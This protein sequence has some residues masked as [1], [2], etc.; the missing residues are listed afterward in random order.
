M[1]TP[2]DSSHEAR[3]TS[4][5]SPASESRTAHTPSPA[6]FVKADVAAGAMPR[7]A[8]PAVIA[9]ARGCSEAASAPAATRSSSESATPGAPSADSRDMRPVVTVPVLS[10]RAVSTRRVRSRASALRMTT[11]SCEARP[12]PTSSAVGVARPSAHGHATTRTATALVRATWR[13]APD[14][15]H[16]MAVSRETAMTTGTKTPEIRSARRWTAALPACASA[17]MRP[18]CDRAVSAPTRVART[19]RAPHVLTVAPVTASPSPTSTG[20]DSPVS[21]EASMADAPETTTPSVATFWPG[22]TRNRSPTARDEA[23]TV[24]SMRPP[25]GPCSTSVASVTPSSRRARRAS[26][27]R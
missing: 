1:E 8:A 24:R 18:I 25:S 5:S 3:P 12:D 26:P 10:S 23:G 11:P 9:R 6:W 13:A 2:R 15:S 16:P 14:A 21:R 7:S 27:A 20:T 4:A 17:T 19:V 22:R